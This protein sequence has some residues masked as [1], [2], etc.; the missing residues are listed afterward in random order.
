MD[1][2]QLHYNFKIYYVIGF[3]LHYG[4]ITFNFYYIMDKFDYDQL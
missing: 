4:F 1:K 2:M 3:V